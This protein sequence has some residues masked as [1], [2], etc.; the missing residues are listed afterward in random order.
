MKAVLS[1][2]LNCISHSM[3]NLR[4]VIDFYVDGFR[5][6]TVGRKLWLLIIIKLIVIFGILKLFFFDDF[7]ASKAAQESSDP[8]DIVRREIVR[9]HDR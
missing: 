5:L 6:M 2:G 3:L 9:S 4:R 7:D 8:S 1:D